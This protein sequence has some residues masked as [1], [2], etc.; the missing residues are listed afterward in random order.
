M[1]KFIK[2]TGANSNP[3]YIPSQNIMKIV[4][5]DSS[6]NCVF[7]YIGGGTVTG[8]ITLADAAAARAL[9]ASLNVSWLACI[10]AGPD[11]TGLVEND[12]AFT[13]VA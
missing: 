6:N 10:L 1:A 3:V 13:A 2:V 12:T 8:S 9:E 7:T 11:A 4:A 5:S